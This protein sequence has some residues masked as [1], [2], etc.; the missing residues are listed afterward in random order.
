MLIERT[1]PVLEKLSTLLGEP[2]ITYWISSKGSI[3][4]SDVASLYALLRNVGSIER[5]SLFVKSD[6]GS[7]Q[8]SLRMVNLLRRY[9]KHLTVL[10]PLE[11]QSAA[12]LSGC[13]R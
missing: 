5:L 4:Q 2:V 12:S 11:C 1:Q 10:A 8:A 9:V 7:G 3:C 6:G 13:C